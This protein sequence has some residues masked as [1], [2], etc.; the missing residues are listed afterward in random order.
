MDVIVGHSQWQAA[1]CIEKDPVEAVLCTSFTFGS[2]GACNELTSSRHW[3]STECFVRAKNS[4]HRLM[5]QKL[6][7]TMHREKSNSAATFTVCTS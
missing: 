5:P 6:S 4:S 3:P 1:L 7:S 2:E